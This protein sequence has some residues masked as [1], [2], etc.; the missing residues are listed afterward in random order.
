MA[1]AVVRL[2]FLQLVLRPSLVMGSRMQTAIKNFRTLYIDY[3]RVHYPKGFHGYCNGLMAY[4]RG[5]CKTGTSM[6]LGKTSMYCKYSENFCENYNEYCT[7]TESSCPL[8]VCTLG[9]QQPAPS[10]S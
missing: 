3:P 8:T 7:L 9:A 6:P 4:V 2:L 1:P 10:C 5:N